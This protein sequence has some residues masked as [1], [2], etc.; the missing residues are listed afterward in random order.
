MSADRKPQCER[1]LRWALVLLD[2]TKVNREYFYFWL[3]GCVLDVA[4][5]QAGSPWSWLLVAFINLSIGVLAIG[6]IVRPVD[7]AFE[8]IG[9]DFK[10]GYGSP[11]WLVRGKYPIAQD[12]LRVK[13]A[14]YDSA[15]FE[16]YVG[17]IAARLNQP[18]MGLRKV[19]PT[20]PEI[21]VLL[22]R[23]LVPDALAFEQLDLSALSPGEFYVGQSSQGLERLSLAKMTHMLVAGQTGAGKTQFLRQMMATVATQTRGSFLCL[24]DMKGGIDFQAFRDLPNFEIATT[25][26]QGDALLDR[27][28]EIYE[29][30]RDHIL[31]KRKSHWNEFSY[32]ELEKEPALAGQ[33]IGP[34]LV[35]VDELAELS[36]KATAKAAKSELQEKIAT[37]ARLS[38]FTGIHLV[39]GTQRPD[40]GTI[41][42]QSKD[43][44]PTRICFSVPSVT[45]STLVLGDMSASTLGNIPGR[46]IYQLS[47]SKVI[48]APLIANPKLN[49]LLVAHT[50]RLRANGFSRGVLCQAATP[51][52]EVSLGRIKR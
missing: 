32:S 51:S 43:N 22:R 41:D 50:E 49:E 15:D 23:S 31:A 24:I 33:P 52:S 6:S 18:I 38:R 36:K 10:Q 48:Q 27:I 26:D 45:A 39:L 28:I 47:G 46:G 17:W 34:L 25:Y 29:Q 7:K 21:E 1:F 42:M 35:I 14:G 2:Q 40:K 44:L 3:L 12:S 8:S 16:R 37:L 5:I 20:V 13:A 11:L 30:R 9:L 4:A 19:S